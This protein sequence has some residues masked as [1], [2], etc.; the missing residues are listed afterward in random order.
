MRDNASRVLGTRLP[1]GLAEQVDARVDTGGYYSSPAAVLRGSLE[2]YF[3]ALYRARR[4][5]RDRFSG[6]EQALIADV[7]NATL[8]ADASAP[9]ELWQEI[10]DAVR[11]EGVAEK[12]GVDG[13][14]LIARLRDLTYTE[15]C[16]L[17]D[18]VERFWLNHRRDEQPDPR[19]LLE[20]P[21]RDRREDPKATRD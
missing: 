15:S 16:A 1:P 3:E 20:E 2:R 9:P 11:H 7:C 14:D 21:A 6:D 4:T 18:A 17:V 5:L 13:A 10:E 19:R 8:F 12:W